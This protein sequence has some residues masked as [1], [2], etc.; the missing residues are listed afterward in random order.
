MQI[1]VPFLKW[2]TFNFLGE[3]RLTTATRLLLNSR[4]TRHISSESGKKVNYHQPL[5]WAAMKHNCAVYMETN[6]EREMYIF[7]NFLM[8]RPLTTAQCFSTN[9]IMI[10]Y[11]VRVAVRLLR[12]N[13]QLRA[14]D[15]ILCHFLFRK[16]KFH[17]YTMLQK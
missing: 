1:S 12:N 2:H 14:V 8:S 10:Y 3:E 17:P 11:I 7:L 4:S 6:G 5:M 16:F 13:C 15:R 9:K